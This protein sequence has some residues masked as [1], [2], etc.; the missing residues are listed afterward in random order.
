[1][2]ALVAFNNTAFGE[3]AFVISAWR[4]CLQAVIAFCTCT[5][6][7]ALSDKYGRVKPLF[8]T[9]LASAVPLFALAVSMNAWAY[10]VT[11]IAAAL[12]GVGSGP[13]SASITLISAYIADI[14]SEAER[15]SCY[16]KMMAIFGFSFAIGPVLGSVLGDLWGYQ[17]L[18][19]IATLFRV[20]Q[21]SYIALVLPESYTPADPSTIIQPSSSEPKKGMKHALK[22]IF[23]NSYISLLAC[24]TFLTAFSDNGVREGL[25]TYLI[26]QLHFPEPEVGVVISVLGF[27]LLISQGLVLPWLS[28]RISEPMIVFIGAIFNFVHIFLFGVASEKWQIYALVVLASIALMGP[29]A[30][31]SL[32]SKLVD[33]A[34]Q[35]IVQGCFS[36]LK[37]VTSGFAPLGL[38]YMFRDYDLMPYPFNFPGVA[39]VMASS[40]LL[41]AMFLSLRLL[42][43]TSPLTTEELGRAE[44]ELKLETGSYMDTMH[45]REPVTTASGSIQD[46]V[47]SDGLS[48]ESR[49]PAKRQMHTKLLGGPSDRSS[50]TFL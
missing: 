30:A 36:S 6:I 39:F 42:F 25:L 47:D 29:P 33:P 11:T 8:F 23:M 34:E 10:V 22:Y 49:Y 41:L 44:I 48:F 35:G 24:I 4:D 17:S 7:G 13:A 45:D 16:G 21:V 12:F 46:Q 26:R 5:I 1:M 18:F 9:C 14:T 27:S 43:L 37:A 40:L 32:I 15:A 31:N 50:D 2:P 28:K 20:L 38:G 3:D 19:F